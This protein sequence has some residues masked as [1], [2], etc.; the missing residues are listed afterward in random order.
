MTAEDNFKDKINDAIK[1]GN[2]DYIADLSNV[3]VSESQNDKDWLKHGGQFGCPV[4]GIDDG[5]GHEQQKQELITQEEE[6]DRVTEQDN[7]FV[8]DTMTKEAKHD[9]PAIKQ[10][11]YAY[12]SGMTNLAIHHKVNSK[13][14]GSGKSYLGLKVISYFPKEHTLILGGVTD[15]AFHYMKGEMVIQGGNPEEYIP[16]APLI[17][18]LRIKKAE[19]KAK[20]ELTAAEEIRIDDKIEKLKSDAFRLIDLRFKIALIADTP[21]EG[22]L[23]AIMSILSQ[24]SKISDYLYTD[25]NKMESAKNSIIGM[26]AFIY[27]RTLD[28]TKNLRAE[29]VFRRFVNVTP[30]VTSEKIQS[31]IELTFMKMGTLP[32]R[33]DNLVVSRSDIEKAK[34]IVA[35]LVKKLIKH[36]ESFGFKESGII[37]PFIKT[38]AKIFP[39]DEVFLM[40]AGDRFTRYLAVV[41]KA[42]MDSRPR[43][44]HKKT[45]ARYPVS[46]FPDLKETYEL[47]ESAGGNVRSYLAIFYNTGLVPFCDI[48]DKPGEDTYIDDQGKTIVIAK[49]S[50]KGRT[51]PELIEQTKLIL[52]FTPSRTEMHSKYL[53]PMINLGLVNWEKRVKKGSEHIYFAADEDAKRVFTLFPDC[54]INDLKLVVNSKENYPTKNILEKDYGL[55][56]ILMVQQGG[57]ENISDIYELQDHKGK[58]ITVSELIDRYLSDPELCFK[59]GWENLPPYYSEGVYTV[60]VDPNLI[61]SLIQKRKKMIF[62]QI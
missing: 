44:V 53:T 27:T 46:L 52:G 13:N 6:L 43:Y 34:E 24:D 9:K 8:I 54:D 51:V 45:G 1:E 42:N 19:L 23:N 29:E 61:L 48:M 2:L 60:R 47:M 35:R 33:Y 18:D 17:L 37:I 7:E 26:P 31:A 22:L 41:T 50:R 36:S 12:L 56:S 10:L 3:N 21:S 5:N 28:D 40:T 20:G 16:I 11:Y 25:K 32:E 62:Y 4:F 14:S 30:N 15:K 57:V 58:K 39:H 38:L 59:Q 49:Q 55:M